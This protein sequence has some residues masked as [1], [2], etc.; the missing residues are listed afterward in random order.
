MGMIHRLL[1]ALLICGSSQA[2][3]ILSINWSD[4]PTGNYYVDF[5]MASGDGVFGNNATS[6]KVKNPQNVSLFPATQLNGWAIEIQPQDFFIFDEDPSIASVPDF[7][8]GILMPFSIASSGPG[9]FAIELTSTNNY[10][11]SGFLDALTIAI[12][13]SSFMSTYQFESINLPIITVS[14][15]GTSALDFALYA[16]NVVPYDTIAAPQL[17][18]TNI[19]EPATWLAVAGAL[20]FLAA[21]KHKRMLALILSA[22]VLPT[23]AQQAWLV[24]GSTASTNYT[25]GV[26]IV[27]PIQQGSDIIFVGIDFSQP[28]TLQSLYKFSTVTR[29]TARFF[30]LQVSALAPAQ[31]GFLIQE[32]KASGYG[33]VWVSDGSAVGTKLAISDRTCYFSLGITLPD[34][35][36]L[37]GCDTFGQNEVWRSDGTLA[38]TYRLL[39]GQPLNQAVI[40]NNRAYFLSN[41]SMWSTDGTIVGTTRAFQDVISLDSV[42]SG[43][44]A[45]FA[46]RLYFQGCQSSTGCELWSTD[47]TAAGTRLSFESVAG[48]SSA[49]G[50]RLLAAS[51]NYLFLSF[52]ESSTGYEL[53]RTDGTQFGTALV[54]D[55]VPGTASNVFSS[56]TSLDQIV[57]FTMSDY[58]LW[59]SDGTPNGTFQI[60]TASDRVL[61][62]LNPT[63][64]VFMANTP[65]EGSEL[66]KTDG[67]LAG[68]SLVKDIIPGA[69]YGTTLL[70]VVGGKA[71]L[72]VSSNA[73]GNSLWESDGTAAGTVPA[74][75]AVVSDS[76]AS[77]QP[78]VPLNGTYYYLSSGIQTCDLNRTDG[79]TP[80]TT[81]VSSIPAPCFYFKTAPLTSFNNF[82]Y[83]PVQTTD[84]YQIW[85][86]GGT[87]Q[88]T[89]KFADFPAGVL[90]FITT[91]GDR[92]Y[93]RAD[94]TTSQAT[95]YAS[96]GTTLTPLITTIADSTSFSPKW[97]PVGQR[98][99]VFSASQTAGESELYITDGT[100]QGTTLLA[101]LD[102]NGSSEPSAFTTVNGLVYFSASV[103]GTPK[104]FR[105]NGTTQGTTALVDLPANAFG[106]YPSNGDTQRLWFSVGNSSV[107][108]YRIDTNELTNIGSYVFNGSP[109]TRNGYTYFIAARSGTSDT[110]IR[111]DG[112]PGGTTPVGFAELGARFSIVY[113]LWAG[114]AL[115]IAAGFDYHYELWSTDGFSGLKRVWQIN[116]RTASRSGVDE[117]LYP[118]N[119]GSMPSLV[120]NLPNGRMLISATDGVRGRELWAYE[121]T[122]CIPATDRTSQLTLTT[123]APTI[124]RLTGRAVQSIRIVNNG[125]ALDNVAYIASGL[126]A[127][128]DIFNRHG[129][130]QCFTPAG[131]YRDIGSIAAGQTVNIVIEFVVKPGVPFSY[132]P[133]VI[134]REGAR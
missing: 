9:G 108:A 80:G 115:Y 27:A 32:P 116:P 21:R 123:S 31:K 17:L 45:V 7:F 6:I 67:T 60:A 8:N 99:L 38:G 48:S 53:W 88:T 132:T 24:K 106:P 15:T 81:I 114:N 39:E 1:L 58:S 42:S 73:I 90:R 65:T 61:R 104:L 101:N 111:T 30:D 23:F 50:F 78:A 12:L 66:W 105:T 19:P 4:L 35:S 44:L 118:T 129:L 117:Y 69:G 127:Q 122:P 3:T 13:D 28:S 64:A 112:T 126:N 107:V 20:A 37:M 91:S 40:F 89:T 86:S 41:Q 70:D 72:R 77:P 119:R 95:L 14:F 54:K 62:K 43:G 63:T 113:D 120:A 131:P 68:T 98:S 29:K 92:L 2:A 47:G 34:G 103:G 26:S 93:I 46:G 71:Y 102:P 87:S 11:G 109:V 133:R 59:R 85:R 76:G 124:N 96:D 51:S 74:V 16:S 84:G 97:A 82:L 25:S 79:T 128:H 75:S 49:P 52:Y 110:I 56:M 22:A 130:T 100:P 94:N 83:F 33:R 121:D 18:D 36:Y 55:I 134:A 10:S 5:Q 57:V 125:P